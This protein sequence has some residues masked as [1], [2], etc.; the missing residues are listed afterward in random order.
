MRAATV[1][2]ERPSA[3][4][5]HNERARPAAA[6]VDGDGEGALVRAKPDAAAGAPA[7]SR[8]VEELAAA[9]MRAVGCAE[10]PPAAGTAPSTPSFSGLPAVQRMK[11]HILQLVR[12]GSG[13]QGGGAV[14][15]SGQAVVAGAG[16]GGG[17]ASLMATSPYP[18]GDDA[19][20]EIAGATNPTGTGF[21]HPYGLA[22]ASRGGASGVPATAVA[23]NAFGDGPEVMGTST[24][25]GLSTQSLVGYDGGSRLAFPNAYGAIVGTLEF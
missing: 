19:I 10:P 11:L 8:N 2:P 4:Q 23:R 25:T 20:L 17:G 6:P 21:G 14:S 9:A 1:P 5:P 18:A 3:A 13:A 22:S 7:P 24:H 15:A 12:P 16:A